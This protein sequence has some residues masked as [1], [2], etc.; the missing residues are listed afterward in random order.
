[1]PSLSASRSRVTITEKTAIL[2][3]SLA[4]TPDAVNGVAEALKAYYETTAIYRAIGLGDG[5][6]AQIVVANTG[7]LEM[8]AGHLREAE[9]LLKSSVE[10]ERALAGDS[11]AVAAAMSYY[12]RILSVTNRNEPA[13]SLLRESVDMASRY[14]NPDSPVALQ[15]KTFLGEA[16]L[17][18]GARDEAAGT[19]AQAHDAALAHYGPAHPLTLRTEIAVAQI[20]AGEGKNETAQQ[21]FTESDGRP[22]QTG[23][24]KAPPTWRWHSKAWVRSN[25]RRGAT[26]TPRPRCEAVALRETVPDDIWELAQAREIGGGPGEERQSRCRRAAQASADLESQL[27]AN[28]PQTL[29]A[30]AALAR[31]APKY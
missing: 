14:A 12:G 28:H 29:R 30:K 8:R 25:P 4:I 23:E 10:R 15:A 7:T 11:A 19:L 6:D 20:A 5:I 31:I 2:F 13:I 1:M 3:N 22:A 27:G 17:A 26:R 16:L 9:S 18:S 24:R 21:Q